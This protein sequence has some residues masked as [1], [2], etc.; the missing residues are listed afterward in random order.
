MEQS[1][2]TETICKRNMCHMPHASWEEGVVSFDRRLEKGPKFYKEVG[3]RRIALVI[4]GRLRSA[5]GELP[6]LFA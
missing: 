6:L 2:V 4:A 5:F 3:I 1:D